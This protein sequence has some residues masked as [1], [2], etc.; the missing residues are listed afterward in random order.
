MYDF[1]QF[2]SEAVMKSSGPDAQRHAEKYI[3]PYIG[4]KETHTLKIAHGDLEAGSP[5][6]IHGHE[7]HDGKHYAIVS[8]GNRG[9]RHSVPLS[10]I[11]KPSGKAA[12]YNDEHAHVHI[13][14]HMT[15][16]G[17]AHDKDAM[18]RELERIKK[19]K[20]HPLHFNNISQ[21]GFTG[22]RRTEA[23]KASYH[24]ELENAIHTVHGFAN[25]PDFKNAVTNRHRARVT[26]GGRGE[27]SELWKRY[28]ATKGATSK[29]DIAI[30]NVNSKK[31][32]GIKISLKKGAGSQ[33]ASAGPEE[34]NAMHH[35]AADEMLAK[36][37]K[38]ANLSQQEKKRI[39]SEIMQH[40]KEISR[41]S[42]N[43]RD[44]KSDSELE[45]LKK[46]AQE[47][48]S[49][50]HKK[51][52]EFNSFLRKEAA[53]GRAKFGEH[54]PNAASY[55]VKSAAGKKAVSIQHVDKVDWSGPPPRIAKPKGMSGGRMRTLN[56]KIDE[57]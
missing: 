6:T 23:H 2:I 56:L 22:G 13:W 29:T 15:D 16:I 24:E 19:D 1:K 50:I 41:Y 21:E 7:V 18:M 52:P 33:L 55:I 4:Q 27:V 26:G 10:K 3:K 34:S 54:S 43:A 49:R 44:A 35:A 57:R 25:H 40:S 14:N 17:I 28:G 51:Y 45:S 8:S 53:T 47:A 42:E 38:Y 48:S 36:H 20:K 39:H 46:K 32:R 12:S 37:L 11:N 9:E 30:E 5:L 31:A